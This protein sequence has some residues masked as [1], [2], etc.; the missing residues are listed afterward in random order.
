MSYKRYTREFKEKLLRELGKGET[1]T[2]VA[3][4]YAVSRQLIYK[5]QMK[6]RD[7]ALDDSQ[8]L[9]EQQLVRQ[10]GELERKVGQLTMENDFLKKMLLRLEQTCPPDKDSRGERRGSG[11]SRIP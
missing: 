10:I 7:G 4:R 2:A 3:R 6:Q 8:P 5:W 11:K 1:V 9:R